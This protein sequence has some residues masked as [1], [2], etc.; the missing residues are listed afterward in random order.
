MTCL[1][2]IG[3][4]HK[5]RASSATD[6]G[7]LVMHSVL[8]RLL[9]LSLTVVFLVSCTNTAVPVQE[10]SF[11]YVASVEIKTTDT[12]ASIEATYGGQ[13][14][15]V[16]TES[17]IAMLGFSSEE[18]QL[19]TLATAVNQ[20]AVE[21]PALEIQ[22]HSA[23]ASGWSAWAGGWSAWAGGWS[24]WAGGLPVNPPSENNV[25]WNQINLLHA[26]RISK[27]YGEGIK[28]AVLDT[29]IDHNHPVFIGRLAPQ[30]EWKD[31]VNNDNNP[32]EASSAFQ[33]YGHGTAVAAIILQVAPKARILPIRVLRGDGR[34]DLDDVIQGIYHA[35]NSGA[36]IINMSLGSTEDTKALYD[37][38]S[39]AWNSGVYT[40]TSS[41]NLGE[42]QVLH[43]G[44]NYSGQRMK[45]SVASTDNSGGL[46]SF[47]NYGNGLVIAAPGESIQSAFP[48]HQTAAYKGT[49]FAAPLAS[50]A[51][52]LVMSEIPS[53][54]HDKLYSYIR[55]GAEY[56]FFQER[57]QDKLKTVVY[58]GSGSLDVANFLRSA[59]GWT[60]PLSKYSLNKNFVSNADL[61]ALEGTKSGWR[62]EKINGLEANTWYTII[63]YGKKVGST[64]G[65]IRLY[66]N[67]TIAAEY[68]LQDSYQ[69]SRTITFRTSA[70][71]DIEVALY[72]DLNINEIHLVK[73]K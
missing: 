16:D 45:V 41:G 8:K 21:T 9:I 61:D 70:S 36:D 28:V 56:G 43:P 44:R 30:S 65:F 66:N 15:I 27:N 3:R 68:S 12:R 17:G 29:G 64:N 24:A 32:Q 26:H 67:D 23:W 7:G 73:G 33:G 49:S 39:Y 25:I 58:S 34:G 46:S 59:E 1:T 69:S 10:E 38:I 20:N 22:G 47:S 55:D 51:M 60:E 42:T 18:A 62:S 35:V 72:G 40:V 48:G 31:F 6:Y 19:T 50:G 14:F 52:A 63:A 57:N 53:Q 11:D 13:A 37:A 54:Y 5:Q 2:S 4:F 71:P